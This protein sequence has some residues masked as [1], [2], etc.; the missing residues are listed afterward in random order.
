MTERKRT[1]EEERHYAALLHEIE[2]LKRWQEVLL[3]EK[4]VGAWKL[5]GEMI[6]AAWR[7]VEKDVP[8]RPKKIRVTAA[9][10]EELV[11]WF[12]AHGAQLPGADERGAEGLH[13]GG[14][15]AGDREPEEHRLEGGGDLRHAL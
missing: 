11:K 3:L 5:K 9:Y 10:E 4:E 15:V 14:E 12:R 6:P 13:A 8:V 2:E 7:T 1:K